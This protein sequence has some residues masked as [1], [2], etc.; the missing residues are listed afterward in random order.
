VFIVSASDGYNLG[1]ILTFGGSSTD[2]LSPMRSKVIALE[3]RG[4]RI[5]AKFRLDR[6]ILSPSGG[7][8]PPFFAAFGLQHLVVSPVGGNL[9]KLNTG[10]QQNYKAS[11][12]QPP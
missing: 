9:R 4:V 2:A 11:P 6:F 5:R 8:T 3:T 1:Q 12:I 10:A 7:E